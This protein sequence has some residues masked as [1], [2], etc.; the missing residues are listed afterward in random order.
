MRDTIER[1]PERLGYMPSLVAGDLAAAWSQVASVIM[2]S[3]KHAVGMPAGPVYV[4]RVSQTVLRSRE[5]PKIG[6]R[7]DPDLSGVSEVRSFRVLTWTEY[8]SNRGTAV[9]QPR[10]ARETDPAPSGAGPFYVSVAVATGPDQVERVWLLGF[11]QGGVDRGREARIVQLD[12]EILA[13]LAGGL[14]PG[15]T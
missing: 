4:R 5:N 15:G 6:W 3:T 7:V 14:L 12:R 13:T 1:V 8:G 11:N 9:E 2:S 10:P